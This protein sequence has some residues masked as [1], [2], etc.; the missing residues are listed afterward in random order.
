MIKWKIQNLQGKW[1]VV[2]ADSRLEALR[3]WYKNWPD[4]HPD[5]VMQ[6]ADLDM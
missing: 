5:Y 3:K 1:R 6:C 2:W 4:E